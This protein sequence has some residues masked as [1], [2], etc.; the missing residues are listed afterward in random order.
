[1]VDGKVRLSCDVPV[2]FSFCGIDC[3]WLVVLCEIL[4]FVKKGFF[5]LNSHWYIIAKATGRLNV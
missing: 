4:K 3:K 2:A 5:F 1:M